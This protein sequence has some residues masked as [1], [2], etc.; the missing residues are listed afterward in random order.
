MSLIFKCANYDCNN[1]L[2]DFEIKKIKEFRSIQRSLHEFCLSCR[3]NRDCIRKLECKKCSKP[4]N[5][6]TIF[7]NICDECLKDSHTNRMRKRHNLHHKDSQINKIREF[8]LEGGTL[9]E[10]DVE[11]KLGI[12]LAKVK[13]IIAV[14][15]WK[16][17]IKIQKTTL[18]CLEELQ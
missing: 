8:L 17:K 7:K 14:L 5:P 16:Y 6:K 2:T 9:N 3:K 1:E 13:K 12:P 11:E 15:K 10:N 4:F 18:Y